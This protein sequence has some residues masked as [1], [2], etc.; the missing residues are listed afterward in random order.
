METEIVVTT[1][2]MFKAVW[3]Q[4]CRG[5]VIIFV[6]QISLANCLQFLRIDKMRAHVLIYIYM[7]V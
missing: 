7:H 6:K 4:F 1:N 2:K 3:M 5:V